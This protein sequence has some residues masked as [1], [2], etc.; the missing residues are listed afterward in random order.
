MPLP[1]LDDCDPEKAAAGSENGGPVPLGVSGDWGFQRPPVDW[2]LMAENSMDPN[3]APF[4]VRRE[5]KEREKERKRGRRKSIEEKNSR[6]RKK[7]D[8]GKKITS[9]S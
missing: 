8:F 2:L 9:S 4:L 6:R 7:N 1:L 3:H 5:L